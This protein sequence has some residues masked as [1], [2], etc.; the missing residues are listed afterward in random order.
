MLFPLAFAIYYRSDDIEEL[1]L[2]IL[3]SLVIGILFTLIFKSDKP[4]RPREGFIIVSMGWIFAALFGSLPFLFYGVFGNN[5]IDCFFET[6]SGFTTTGAT[7]LTDIGILPKGIL[8]WR[9]F[10]HWLGGMGIIMLTIAILPIL[11]LSSNQL[12]KAEVPGPTKDKISPKIKDTAKILWY[13]YIGMTVLET[14][15]LMIGK[16]SFFDALC[17]TFGTLA[18][19]GFSTSNKSVAGFNSLYIE[20]VILIFMYLAGTNFILHFF[21]IKGKF[22][23]FFNNH[24]WRFYTLGLIIA[25]LLLSLNIYFSN[26]YDSFSTCLRYASFQVVSITTTTGFVTADFELWPYF[27]KI[28]LII[29]MFMGGCS[30]STGGSMKQI[31]VMVSLKF[32][33]NEI[34][35][36][37]YP[38]AFFSLKI[39][40]ETFGDFVIKNIVAFFILFVSIFVLTTLFL[41]FQGYDIVTSFSASIATLGNIGPGL[42]KVGAVENYAFFDNA[43]KLV[44]SFNMLIGRLEIYSVLILIYTLFNPKKLH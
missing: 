1:S 26:L 32:A 29:L 40:K 24:E 7:V 12:Y 28:A 5:Y 17:H 14:V 23:D 4:L 25:S 43:S 2:S 21:L 20:I 15:L 22:K 3:I 34:K 33:L 10:T 6:M 9:S 41:S 44:L 39:G 11:G 36:L 37:T 42:S 30:G 38:R 19:G 27:S 13:I 16:M 31:R 35:K 18:T 8:F